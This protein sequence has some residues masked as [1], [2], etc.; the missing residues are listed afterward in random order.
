MCIMSVTERGGE[1]EGALK[2]GAGGGGWMGEGFKIQDYY[3]IREIKTRL[4]INHI[5][6]HNNT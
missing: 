2:R 5:T 6:L 4:N 3:L 1:G